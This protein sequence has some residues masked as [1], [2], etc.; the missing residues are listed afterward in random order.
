MSS[1]QYNTW[2]LSAESLLIK[3]MNSKIQELLAEMRVS[4]TGQ[5]I[6]K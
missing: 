5:L 6:E 1:E 2:Q 3:L 4:E